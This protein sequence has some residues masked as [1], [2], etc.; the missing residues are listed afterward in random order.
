MV[1][2]IVG[3]NIGDFILFFYQI[4]KGINRFQPSKILTKMAI[5]LGK[6]HG[7]ICFI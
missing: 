2:L 3:L 1:E 6:F 4:T 5:V 7:L